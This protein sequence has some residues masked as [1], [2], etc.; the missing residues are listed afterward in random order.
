MKEWVSCR[1]FLDSEG[2][3][4]EYFYL[5]CSQSYDVSLRTFF[6]DQSTSLLDKG[7]SAAK[8][9]RS[10]LDSGRLCGSLLICEVC[11]SAKLLVNQA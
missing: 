7:I 6:H 10:F 11:E 1:S 2:T 9:S 5:V 3:V 8:L 4:W